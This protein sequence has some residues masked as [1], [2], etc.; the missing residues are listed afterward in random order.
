LFSRRGVFELERMNAT[1]PSYFSAQLM[2][3]RGEPETL[4]PTP[5][6]AVDTRGH[7]GETHTQIELFT[8]V[9]KSKRACFRLQMGLWCTHLEPRLPRDVLL[10]LPRAAWA[11]VRHDVF[12][13]ELAARLAEGVVVLVEDAARTDLEHVANLRGFA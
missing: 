9:F 10:R 6:V 7:N 8:C 2:P 11:G 3:S 1:G 4:T 12:G 5:A 13:V